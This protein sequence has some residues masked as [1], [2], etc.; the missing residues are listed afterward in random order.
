[1]LVLQAKIDSL[2]GRKSL[3]GLPLVRNTGYVSVNS[4]DLHLYKIFKKYLIW[5]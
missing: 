2:D 4:T 3:H 5:L 1:M